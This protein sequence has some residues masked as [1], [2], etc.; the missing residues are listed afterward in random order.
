MD[1]F[2]AYL[3]EVIKSQLTGKQVEEKPSSIK[4]EDILKAAKEQGLETIVVEGILRLKLNEK[5]LVTCKSHALNA[6]L[7]SIMQSKEIEKIQKLMEE[8]R[9]RHQFMKGSILRDYYPKC[10][11]RE[12]GDIDILVDEAAME[13]VCD[14]MKEAGYQFVRKEE[15]HDIYLNQ[16]Y[17]M[18]EVHRTLYSTKVDKS[19][20]NYFETLKYSKLKEGYQYTYEFNKED[21]YLYMIA[22]MA[23]HFYDTGCGIRSLIDIY[24]YETK[25][26]NDLNRSYIETELK[27]CGLFLFERRMRRLSFIWLDQKESTP[28]DDDLFE[29]MLDCGTYG[30]SENGIWS[31]FA[32]SEMKQG[33]TKG[34]FKLYYYFPPYSYISDEYTWLKKM[35][36]LLPVAWVIRG[37]TGLIKH[38]G[39]DKLQLI[40]TIDPEQIKKMHRIYSELHLDFHG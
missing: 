1:R 33:E 5:E 21:F 20:H 2:S 23:K 18:V 36:F 34:K 37:V 29:Y 19:L 24:V 6:V 30:K 31:K 26:H 16:Q 8:N 38:K 13:K 35:P 40:N 39:E 22:H 4:T 15:H 14:L 32:K 11:F 3:G 28:Y 9:I 17:V 7:R 25:F 27:K 10:Q 12:M